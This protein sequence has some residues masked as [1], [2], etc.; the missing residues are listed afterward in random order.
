[1]SKRYGQKS[2]TFVL[3]YSYA[4][5]LLQHVKT[6]KIYLFTNI[7]WIWPSHINSRAVASMKILLPFIL[8]LFSTRLSLRSYAVPQINENLYH[9]RVSSRH[10]VVWQSVWIV[11]WHSHDKDSE[12]C[13]FFEKICCI[14]FQIVC[15]FTNDFQQVL[16]K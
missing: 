9:F 16:F 4:C 14:C 10:I 5:Q 2:S 3:A 13:Y 8:L 12:D 15:F 11:S 6:G 1:M 7:L